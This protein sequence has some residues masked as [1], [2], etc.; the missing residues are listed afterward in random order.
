MVFDM[1][2]FLHVAEAN[3]R[4]NGFICCPCSVCKNTKDYSCSKTLHYHLLQSSF[5][6]DYNCWTKHRERG[7][8]MVNNEK[9]EDND[10][11]P[12]FTEHGDTT[13]GEDEAEEEPI[14]DEP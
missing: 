2:N 10:N 12:M 6:S 11:Y 8:I 5:M 7:V 14:V 13:I 9:E 3:K 4:A 1:H